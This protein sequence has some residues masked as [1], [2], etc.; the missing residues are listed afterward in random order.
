VKAVL[1]AVGVVALL[2]VPLFVRNQMVYGH[3]LA[4]NAFYA[5]FPRQVQPASLLSPYAFAHWLY[6]LGSGTLLSFVGEFGYMDIQFPMWLYGLILVPMAV[7]LVASIQRRNKSVMRWVL[8]A[9]VGLLIASYVSYN[10]WQ[11]QPQARY[12]FPAIAPMAFW[13]ACG[14][15]RLTGKRLVVAGCAMLTLLLAADLTAV[16]MLPGAFA[17]RVQLSNQ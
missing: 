10:L 4:L 13:M 7:C 3:P 14:L 16:A 15:K 17:Q 5:Y 9:F 11:V 1:A 2:T 12:L 8:I 6:V